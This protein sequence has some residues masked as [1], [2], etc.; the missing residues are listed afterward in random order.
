MVLIP[1]I[2]G[3]RIL[4]IGRRKLLRLVGLTTCSSFNQASSDVADVA[5]AEVLLA[6]R[7]YVA[8][9]DLGSASGAFDIRV[10]YEFRGLRS[11]DSHRF[12]AFL[13]HNVR[14]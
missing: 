5:D 12:I 2:S 8:L 4:E 3:P 7:L 11:G 10:K 14:D 6:P 9:V 1:A 13:T